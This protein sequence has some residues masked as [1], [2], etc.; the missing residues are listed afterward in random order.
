MKTCLC[1]NILAFWTDVPVPA[2]AKLDQCCSALSLEAFLRVRLERDGTRNG[3]TMTALARSIAVV[4]VAG[5]RK[6][7]LPLYTAICLLSLAVG[8]QATEYALGSV[9][10]RQPLTSELA[11]RYDCSPR[12]ELSNTSQ[13]NLKKLPGASSRA[14]MADTLIK[15]LDGQV[16]Y[17]HR[18]FEESGDLERVSGNITSTISNA[19]GGIAPRLYSLDGAQVAIWGE[20]KLEEISAS[21]QEY[22]EIKGLIEQK[23]GLLVATPGDINA[24]KRD[25]RPVYRVIGGDGLAVIVYQRTAKVVVVQH[26]IAAAGILAERNFDS[27]ARQFFKRDQGSPATDLSKWHEIAFMIRRLALN[28]TSE[29]ANRIVDETFNSAAS[30]KY[31]SHVWAVIPTSVLKHLRDGTYMAL[32]IFE[33]QTEFPKIRGEIIA[34]LNVAPSEPFSEFLLYMLGRFSEAVKVNPESPIRTVLEYA[35]AHSTLRRVLSTTFQQVARPGDRELLKSS[36]VSYFH[37]TKDIIEQ[38]GPDTQTPEYKEPTTEEKNARLSKK[39]FFEGYAYENIKWSSNEYRDGQPLLTQYLSYLNQFP[40]RYNSRPIAFRLP[41]FAKLTEALL[42]HLEEVL[43]DRKSPHFDDAAYFL[44][45]LAYHRG[46]TSEALKKFELAI[47]LFPKNYSQDNE[48]LDYPYLALR[49]TARILSTLS[50]EDAINHVQNSEILSSQSKV[51]NSVLAS[52]YHSHQYQSVMVGAQKALAKFGIS[53]ASLPVTTDPNRISATLT[54][55]GLAGDQNLQEIVYLYHA[56]R[57]FAQ[58]EQVLSDVKKLSPS[59][60]AQTL[61]VVIVKYSLTSDSD[62]KRKTAG[63]GPRPQHKDLRQAIFVIQRSLEALPKTAAFSALRRWLHYKRIRLLAQFDPVR[64][65]AANAEFHDEFPDSSLLDD[66][67]AEQV[68]VEAVAIGDM[69][70]AAATFDILRQRYPNGNAIDNAYSWMA[71]GWACT[72]QPLKAREID[73]QIVRLFPSTRHARFAR[74]R[75]DKP[76]NCEALSEFFNWDYEAMLWRG[77]TRINVIQESLKLGGVPPRR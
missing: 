70:K 1:F 22:R 14:A 35:L 15:S 4:L 44:G 66:V 37:E 18:K 59:S 52:F 56:S 30:R 19:L 6:A 77:R 38:H 39:N 34:Q 58:L 3:T 50:P 76:T 61:K 74:E 51:W 45:W 16:L 25:G 47:A 20:I 26:L 17:A 48:H 28:T 73:Q 7:V 71:I 40:E 32:D 11:A 9:N 8:C 49:Q 69:T 64:V 31:Y 55:L 29:N 2:E 60:M 57:E 21:V 5:V 41:E 67:M 53:I 65:A 36:Q 75:L 46:N 27:Q 10:L 42:P 68:F 54:K 43:K 12:T 13:C 33:S 63:P 72:G 23:Y 62:L 24:A